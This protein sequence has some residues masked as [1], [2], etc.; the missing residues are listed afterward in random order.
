MAKPTSEISGVSE[1]N[2][3][4]LERREGGKI[5]KI[6]RELPSYNR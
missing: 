4:S 6:F 5:V 1:R 2:F 3:V